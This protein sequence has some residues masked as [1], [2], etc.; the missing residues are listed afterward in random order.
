MVTLLQTV[1]FVHPSIAG[2]ALLAGLIPILVHLINRRRYV[3]VPWAAMSFLLA[4]NRRSARRIRLE[5][6]LLL[7]TRIA[8]VVLL[9]LAV[10]RPF[11][12]ALPLWPS[13]SSRVHRVL[14]LDNS[15]SMNARRADG[16][17]RF[18]SPSAVPKTCL[19]PSL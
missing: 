12:P 7:L 13:H 19:T 4:A 18:E 15:L 9:G 14:L 6:S 1:P 8:V 17:T 11:L 16:A 3:R 2:L 10:A 5:Q